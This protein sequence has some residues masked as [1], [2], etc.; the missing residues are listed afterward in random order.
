MRN[1]AGWSDPAIPRHHAVGDISTMWMLANVSDSDSV[2]IEVGQTVWVTT[3]RHKFTQRVVRIGLQHGGCRQTPD[4]LQQGE[5]L[6][7]STPRNSGCGR[8]C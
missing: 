2:A 5:V 8:C 4:G 3:D 6:V 7:M 1:R